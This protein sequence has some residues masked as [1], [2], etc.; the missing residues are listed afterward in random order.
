MKTKI[1]LAII[2]SALVSLVLVIFYF[3]DG[4]GTN[5]D[6]QRDF[7]IL[8]ENEQSNATTVEWL[9]NQRFEHYKDNLKRLKVIYFDSLV[10]V[11]LGLLLNFYKPRGIQVSFIDLRIPEGL[12]YLIIVLGLLYTWANF[13]LEFNSSIDSRMALKE[14]AFH[15]N[16]LKELNLSY[17]QMPNH[18]LVDNAIVDN[19]MSSFFNEF[20]GAS[21]SSG[22]KALYGILLFIFQSFGPLENL[23]Y[24]PSNS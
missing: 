20:E 24:F 17:E 3:S 11:L 22:N 18:L 16:G 7:V 1:S 13:G 12:L 5:H 2:V 9:Y 15:Q 10:L 4:K 6:Y 21:D 14:L 8:T 23:H 19:W